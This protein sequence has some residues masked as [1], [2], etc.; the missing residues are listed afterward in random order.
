MGFGVDVS[1]TVLLGN[2][3]ELGESLW[4]GLS[5][6]IPIMDHHG[7]FLCPDFCWLNHQ[8]PWIGLVES[9]CVNPP[10]T[11]QKLMDFHSKLL[12]FTISIISLPDVW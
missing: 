9:N 7:W 3:S 5:R 11:I 10:V 12:E 4:G 8:L 2:F 1:S 6:S